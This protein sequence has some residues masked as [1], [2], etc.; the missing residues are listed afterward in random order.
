M[1]SKTL[2]INVNSR[3]KVVSKDGTSQFFK[4]IS[5]LNELIEQRM[6]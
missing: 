1:R 5:V 6:P 2:A 4:D 3:L